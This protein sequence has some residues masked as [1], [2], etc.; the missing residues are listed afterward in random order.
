MNYL[1]HLFFSQRTP[2]SFTGNLMGD[3]KPSPELIE[4]LP[5][6]VLLGISNHKLVDRMTDQFHAVRQ[7]RPLFSR[8]R[9]RYAGIVT[10]IAFDYFLIKHWERYENMD[11]SEFVERCYSG[12][13]QSRQ[14]M[15]ERMAYVVTKMNQHDWLSAYQSLDGIAATIDQVSKRM[16][17]SNNMQGGVEEIVANYQPIESTFLSLFD[18]LQQAVAEAAIES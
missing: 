5:Q 18:H 4:T 16:R 7:L 15:P 17:F 13:Q 1:S 11:F 8:Q 14:W 12:L 10:D 6:E 2:L 9:R 3:F